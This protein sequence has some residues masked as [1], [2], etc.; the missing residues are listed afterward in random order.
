MPSWSATPYGQPVKPTTTSR[1]PSGEITA[2]RLV[3][4][5]LQVEGLPLRDLARQIRQGGEV[6][7]YVEEALQRLGVNPM[8]YDDPWPGCLLRTVLNVNPDLWLAQPALRAGLET[9]LADAR[10][11]LGLLPEE[12]T[13]DIAAFRKPRRR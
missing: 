1:G 8:P 11:D 12:I 13:E 2:P 9:V 10:L 7:L 6:L 3:Q 5:R 4:D